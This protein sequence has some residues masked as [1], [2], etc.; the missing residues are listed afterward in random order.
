MLGEIFF[1]EAQVSLLYAHSVQ[2]IDQSQ[3]YYLHLT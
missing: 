3:H 2:T 1:P